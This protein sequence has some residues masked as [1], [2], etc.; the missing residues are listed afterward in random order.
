MLVTV[1]W[2]LLF[3]F[4]FG[5]VV[6]TLLR[7]RLERPVRY[8]GATTPRTSALAAHPGDVGYFLPRVL[9]ARDHKEQV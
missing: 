2:A 9:M 6:G 1:L 3:A 4:V 5:L 8:I 7:Q